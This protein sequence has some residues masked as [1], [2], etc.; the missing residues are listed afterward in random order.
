MYITLTI[1]KVNFNYAGLFHK[2]LDKKY[3]KLIEYID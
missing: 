3:H 2:I 1:L